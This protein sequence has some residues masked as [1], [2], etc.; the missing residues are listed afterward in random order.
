MAHW[1]PGCHPGVRERVADELFVDVF[2]GLVEVGFKV[3]IGVTG[4]DVREQVASL[5]KAVDAIAEDGAAGFAMMEADL[6][7]GDP[8]VGMDHAAHWETSYLMSIRPELVDLRRLAAVASPE[9]EMD[10]EKL[11]I[12]GRNPLKHASRSLGERAINAMVD[13]IGA[14]ARQVLAEVAGGRA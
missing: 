4:H 7:P 9:E 8:E 10:W 6:N 5:Q 14:K 3:V 2:K 1:R 11:G 12:G 13:A